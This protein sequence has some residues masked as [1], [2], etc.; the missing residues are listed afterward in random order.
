MPFFC[1]IVAKGAIVNSVSSQVSGPNG[2]KIVCNV[3][4]FILLNLF[5][6]G[7]AILQSVSEWQH[8]KVDWSVKNAD[9]STLNGCH[10]NVP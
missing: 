10:G 7:I 6:I 4:K 1:R 5:E 3:E 8:D 9:F 2:T